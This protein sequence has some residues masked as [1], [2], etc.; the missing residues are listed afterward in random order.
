[1]RRGT[2]AS[3][4]SIPPSFPIEPPLPLRRANT[5]ASSDAQRTVGLHAGA[6]R[7][8]PRIGA[9]DDKRS[10]AAL[11]RLRSAPAWRMTPRSLGR[12]AVVLA[13]VFAVGARVAA[14]G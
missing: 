2:A 6:E 5:S 7:A 11:R 8:P 9:S 3:P 4:R 12:L 1:M 13:V 14:T 10:G